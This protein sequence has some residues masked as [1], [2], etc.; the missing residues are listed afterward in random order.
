MHKRLLLLISLLAGPLPLVVPAATAPAAAT[1]PTAA[2]FAAWITTFPAATATD[3]V[4]LREFI[5]HYEVVVKQVTP[6]TAKKLLFQ[7]SDKL[8]RD[9]THLA[10]VLKPVKP[11]PTMTPALRAETQEASDW[12]ARKFAP[13]LSKAPH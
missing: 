2:Q 8:Q 9:Q 5:G 11:S 7:L 4:K 3:S 6:A 13:F 10:A 1:A 12:L